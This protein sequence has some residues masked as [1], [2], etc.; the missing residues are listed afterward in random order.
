MENRLPGNANISFE[1]LDASELIFKLDEKGICA[2]AGSACS[3]GNPEPSHVL[4]AIGL[5]RNLSEGTL[6]TTFG[7][8]NT[9]QD[10][11]FLVDSLVN[12]IQKKY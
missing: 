6:R 4:V 1:G 10:V 2:S 3:T 8:D 12:I 5:D 7:K 11:E 9:K